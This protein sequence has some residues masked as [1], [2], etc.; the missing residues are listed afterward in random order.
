MAIWR[1][2]VTTPPTL[3]RWSEAERLG[4]ALHLGATAGAHR[5]QRR[6]GQRVVRGEQPAH[7]L[8]VA[9]TGVGEQ[10]E[11]PGQA[12]DDLGA[13]ALPRDQEVRRDAG[14]PVL[15]RQAGQRVVTQ[16]LLDA[17]GGD[18]EPVGY[19]RKGE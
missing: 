16:Q 15:A 14:H 12:L 19:L 2:T 4:S 13:A 11:H 6:A 5:L 3:P 10:G 9:V 1:R 18:A 7:R 8:P 17:L